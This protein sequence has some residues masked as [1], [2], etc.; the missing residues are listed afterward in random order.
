MAVFVPYEEPKEVERIV[1]RP[2]MGYL[3]PI[4]KGK[5]KQVADFLSAIRDP[6]GPI[7]FDGQV[8]DPE[9]YAIETVRESVSGDFVTPHVIEPSFGIDRS[10]YTVLEHAYDEDTIDGERRVVLR[11]SPDI[12]PIEVAVFPLVKALNEKA[13]EVFRLLRRAG[14]LVEY[15]D[16]GTIGRR[17]R[18]QDEI[19]T[20]FAV[21]IDHET[22]ENS[23]VTIR[24]R[25]TTK[26]VRS[27]IES[28]ADGLREMLVHGFD[29]K[30]S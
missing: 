2:N 28:L 6:E 12:A 11:L 20:P 13:L 10:I 30:S 17:Y 7:V 22:I 29:K 4:Y 27:S 19:G 9:G 1:V 3:G 5:A 15:D 24:D 26:Q 14:L 21:T 18:R 16:S 8:V 23:T 25:D